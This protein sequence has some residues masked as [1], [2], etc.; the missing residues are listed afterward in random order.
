MI[1]P[2]NQQYDLTAGWEE[3]IREIKKTVLGDILCG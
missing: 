1:F 2:Y 3:T